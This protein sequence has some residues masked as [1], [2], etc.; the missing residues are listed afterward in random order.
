M[1]EKLYHSPCPQV[2]LSQVWEMDKMSVDNSTA[3]A[4]FLE[5]M[6]VQEEN[7]KSLRLKELSRKTSTG[8]GP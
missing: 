5:I 6:E 4:K 8:G 3:K 1:N 7:L 2:M